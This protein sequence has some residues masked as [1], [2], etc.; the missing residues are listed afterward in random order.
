MID[1]C[2]LISIALDKR[3]STM[4]KSSRCDKDALNYSIAKI[5]LHSIEEKWYCMQISLKSSFNHHLNDNLRRENVSLL[6]DIKLTIELC[7]L[8]KRCKSTFKSLSSE[9]QYLSRSQA[10]K[11]N[12]TKYL[13]Q[14]E[15]PKVEEKQWKFDINWKNLSWV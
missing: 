3:N 10:K 15:A 5:R 6:I 14:L 12:N 1:I 8:F 7:K 11:T 2:D 9:Q 4:Q 13:S